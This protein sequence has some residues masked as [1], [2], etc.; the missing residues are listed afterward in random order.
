MTQIT[1]QGRYSRQIMIEGFGPEGQER[2]G[3]AKVLIA[4]AGGLGSPQAIYL[5]AAGAG[6]IQLLDMDV[7]AASNLNRQILHWE[8]N[9]GQPKVNSALEKLRRINS[10][11]CIEARNEKITADNVDELIAGQDLVLDAMDNFDTRKVLNQAC[12]RLGIPFIYGGVYGLTG[13]VSTFVPGRTACLQCLF[14]GDLPP[15]TFPVLGPTPGV[16]ASLQVTEAIKHLIDLGRPLYDRLLIYDGL[17]MSFKE[18]NIEPR[19]DCPA[20]GQLKDSAG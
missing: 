15:S 4:G 12:M 14:P 17:D 19:T 3:A 7:V 20:C 10:T 1:D 11:L 6:R 5:A 9:L 16:I 8:E 2:L 13:M 18:I